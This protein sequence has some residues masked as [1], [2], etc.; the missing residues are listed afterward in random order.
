MLLNTILF[1]TKNILQYFQINLVCIVLVCI[2]ALV[3]KTNKI[4]TKKQMK[5]SK[6][7]LK[8]IVKSVAQFFAFTP[9]QN[10]AQGVKITDDDIIA[11]ANSI[12]NQKGCTTTLEIKNQLRQNGMKVKQKEVSIIMQTNVQKYGWC[13]TFNGNF[14]TYY[15]N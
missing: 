5:I 2:F 6:T 1:F 12:M 10:F 9:I 11:T 3:K 7:S 13:H 4:Q 15:P 8:G 14:R